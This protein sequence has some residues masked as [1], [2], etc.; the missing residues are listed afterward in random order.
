MSSLAS[1]HHGENEI[2]D[3]EICK[4]TGR[5]FE[6]GV[7]VLLLP[8]LISYAGSIALACICIA[9]VDLNLEGL[10]HSD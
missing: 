1:H 8:S 5:R 3:L 10:E 7:A 6:K 4:S 2:V 9:N